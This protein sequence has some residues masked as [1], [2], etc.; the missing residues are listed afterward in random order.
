MW[1]TAWNITEFQDGIQLNEEFFI[2]SDGTTEVL[3]NSTLPFIKGFYLRNVT[4]PVIMEVKASFSFSNNNI[5]QVEY[6]DSEEYV[7]PYSDS[8]YYTYDEISQL[9]SKD[10]RIARNEI[11]A[12]HSYVFNDETLNNYFSQFS[13]YIPTGLSSKEIENSLNEFEKY[14]VEL[15]KE[16]EEYYS[17]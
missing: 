8:Q 2:D 16:C 1:E 11:F 7:L 12:R 13:W 15:I 10:L 9:S 17:E 3:P 14:N 6:D 5:M 4:S